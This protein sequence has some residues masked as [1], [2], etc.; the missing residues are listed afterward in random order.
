M[1]CIEAAL[2]AMRAERA[3]AHGQRAIYR[4]DKQPDIHAQSFGME[5]AAA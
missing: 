5:D 1:M 2:K 4:R 3:E